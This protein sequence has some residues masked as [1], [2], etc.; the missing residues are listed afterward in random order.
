MVIWHVVNL[1]IS[2]MNP[3]VVTQLINNLNS[4]FGQE[5]PITIHH[6]KTHDSLGMTLDYS[7]G[8]SSNV[9]LHCETPAGAAT[10]YGWDGKYKYP[11]S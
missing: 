1:K 8:T 4:K 3:Q 5:A 6:V 10:Q 9:E 2:H 7:L 11:C